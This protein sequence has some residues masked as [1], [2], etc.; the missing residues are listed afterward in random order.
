MTPWASAP[1]SASDLGQCCIENMELPAPWELR[2][3]FWVP[4]TGVRGPPG[5][6]DI[7]APQ[8]REEYPAFAPP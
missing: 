5:A 7:G 4:A 2:G 1:K 6:G 3:S 8:T